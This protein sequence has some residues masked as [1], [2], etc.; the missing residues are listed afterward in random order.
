MTR[1]PYKP[2]HGPLTAEVL[3]V[4]KQLKHWDDVWPHNGLCVGS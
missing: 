1:T 3:G 4:N 2:R